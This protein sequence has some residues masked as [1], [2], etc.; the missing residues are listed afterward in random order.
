M[1]TIHTQARRRERLHGPGWV[2]GEDTTFLPPPPPHCEF[3]VPGSV[4]PTTP[5][6]IHEPLFGSPP[7]PRSS[8]HRENLKSGR[9]SDGRA[10]RVSNHGWEILQGD[11]RAPSR[12]LRILF[13][14]DGSTVFRTRVKGLEHV[15]QGTREATLDYHSKHS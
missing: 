1:V 10:M 15:L 3:R 2:L 13:F 9:F 7:P 14:L 4:V 8:F 11:S 5:S 6:L 12:S